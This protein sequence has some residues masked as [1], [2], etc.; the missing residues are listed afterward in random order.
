MAPTHA[1]IAAK[2][3]GHA[4]EDSGEIK[5]WHAVQIDISEVDSL[6]QC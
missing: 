5:N 4:N 3:H 1:E 2:M 6:I